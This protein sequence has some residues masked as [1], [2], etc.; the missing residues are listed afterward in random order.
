MSNS[1]GQDDRRFPDFNFIAMDEPLTEHIDAVIIR[2]YYNTY[3]YLFSKS[4]VVFV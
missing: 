4:E 2:Y 1:L 3:V